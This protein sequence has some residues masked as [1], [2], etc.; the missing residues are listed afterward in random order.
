MKNSLLELIST[1]QIMNVILHS[2]I[3]YHIQRNVL[4][5]VCLYSKKIHT[6]VCTPSATPTENGCGKNPVSCDIFYT[7]GGG[8]GGITKEYDAVPINICPWQNPMRLGIKLKVTSCD[9]PGCIWYVNCVQQ[10]ST[11]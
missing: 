3:D 10:S 8:A 2:F 5:L 6:R 1:T 11:N 4:I 7:G 9:T